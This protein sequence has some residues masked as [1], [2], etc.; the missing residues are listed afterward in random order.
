VEGAVFCHKCGTRIPLLVPNQP[1]ETTAP[2]RAPKLSKKKELIQHLKNAV[3]R[4][5]QCCICSTSENLQYFEFGLGMLE[6]RRRWLEAGAS[7]ALSA[8]SLPL[9]GFGMLTLPTKEENWSVVRMALAVCPECLQEKP[10]YVLHPWFALLWNYGYNVFF[11]T[12]QLKWFKAGL[13]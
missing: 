11:S 5:S 3:P 4:L 9:T 8:L 2:I 12:E 7:V 1:R 13:R 10:E 6:T